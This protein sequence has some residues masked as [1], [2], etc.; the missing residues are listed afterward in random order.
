MPP[1]GSTRVNIDIEWRELPSWRIFFDVAPNF[2]RSTTDDSRPT[3]TFDQT[4][5]LI[6]GWKSEKRFHRKDS[7]FSSQTI[8]TTIEIR[9]GRKIRTKSWSTLLPHRFPARW[10]W[11]SPNKI[12]SSWQNVHHHEDMS[13]QFKYFAHHSII[14]GY[15]DEQLDHRLLFQL[16]S[17]SLE[18]K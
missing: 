10:R 15:F 16:S 2:R 4:W 6:S 3:E 14:N 5:K 1:L 12:H 17:E 8:I 13:Q 18:L 11:R 9:F 7:T